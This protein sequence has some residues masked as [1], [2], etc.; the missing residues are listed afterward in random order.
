MSEPIALAIDRAS[1]Q[2]A[3]KTALGRRGCPSAPRRSPAHP[4]RSAGL[5]LLDPE[6]AR[7]IREHADRL[8]PCRGPCA[9]KCW[10][11]AAMRRTALRM[12]CSA[13]CA[14]SAPRGRPRHVRVPPACLVGRPAHP[15]RRPRGQP[16]GQAGT[17]ATGR[18][19]RA[20]ER[21]LCPSRPRDRRP[22][23]PIRGRRSG[24]GE[25]GLRGQP[26]GADL[27]QTRSSPGLPRCSRAA[28]SSARSPGRMHRPAVHPLPAQP[29]PEWRPPSSHGGLVSSPM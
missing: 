12:P 28:S 17:P 23:P 19:R 13:A 11:A 4:R 8:P 20:A 16:A 24:P 21:A 5:R 27:R 25:A 26:G 7:A 3:I 29:L 9:P 2:T 6:T 22:G 15:R 14:S 18:A 10:C 1:E